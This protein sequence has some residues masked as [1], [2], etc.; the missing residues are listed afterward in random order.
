MH[1][2]VPDRPL[3]L[4]DGLPR[5]RRRAVAVRPGAP[6]PT[7]PVGALALDG[8][9]R[10]RAER[11]LSV[12]GGW[13]Q[14]AGRLEPVHALP[15]ADGRAA[16]RAERVA[17]AAREPSRRHTR[18][19]RDR[20]RVGHLLGAHAARPAGASRATAPRAQVL[21]RRALRRGLL[22]ADGAARGRAAGLVRAPARPRLARRDR[23]PSRARRAASCARSRPGS[24]ARTRS[25]SPGA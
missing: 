8:R 1:R 17:G 9:D 16:R 18:R 2:H 25:R 12:I 19:G 11:R 10:G 23:R 21:L 5:L 3:H 7:G 22:P 4:P 13:V 15:G 6:A 20:R 24:S 14:I